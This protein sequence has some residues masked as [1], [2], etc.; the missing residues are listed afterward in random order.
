MIVWLF[1][2]AVILQGGKYFRYTIF[3]YVYEF[4]THPK[5]L[6]HLSESWQL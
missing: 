2:L 1:K 6:S 5:K 3:M 4:Q